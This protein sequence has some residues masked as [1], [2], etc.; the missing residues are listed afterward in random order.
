MFRKKKKPL[1]NT[2]STAI[3][4]IL[5]FVVIVNIFITSAPKVKDL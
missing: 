2:L 5:A 4:G 1:S 3:S